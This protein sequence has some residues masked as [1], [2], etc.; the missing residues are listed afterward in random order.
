MLCCFETFR[1]MTYIFL[2]NLITK[3]RLSLLCVSDRQCL[4]VIISLLGSGI[5]AS[6]PLG[7]PVQVFSVLLALACLPMVCRILPSRVLD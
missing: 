7:T 5:L 4:I 3:S 6:K 2:E 1:G